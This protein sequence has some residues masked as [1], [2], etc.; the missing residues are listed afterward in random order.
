MPIF[1]HPTHVDQL[2]QI[3][4]ESYP[5]TG[6]VRTKLFALYWG[7]TM[8]LVV[9]GSIAAELCSMLTQYPKILLGEDTDATDWRGNDT[10]LTFE[11]KYYNA[12]VDVTA[13]VGD[14]PSQWKT[15]DEADAFIY[16]VTTEEAIE[17]EKKAEKAGDG[18]ES[19]HQDV[20]CDLS[21]E[22]D[23]VTRVLVV[24]GHDATSLSDKSAMF[25]ATWAIDRGFEYI[26]MPKEGRMAT[27]ADR[28][29]ESLPRLMEALESTQWR[30]MQPKGKDGSSSSSSAVRDNVFQSNTTTTTTTSCSGGGDISD[31]ANPFLVGHSD[32]DIHSSGSRQAQAASADS[33]ER[34]RE[35]TH[36]SGTNQHTTNTEEEG[37][38]GD[39]S[40]G[41]VGFEQLLEQAMKMRESVASGALGDAERRAQ[42][43]RFATQFAA[44][45][46][47]GEGGDSS[48][49]DDDDGGGGGGGSD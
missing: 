21:V 30:S 13:L 6:N 31:I 35:S 41:N 49:D 19:K 17:I 14:D 10:K 9:K 20:H 24:A 18:T 26:Y 43:E 22:K 8:S 39:N 1:G 44:M 4:V 40:D 25:W 42:A 3:S 48:D 16:V 29:K 27:A 11:T 36:G 12:E 46:D 47:F 34:E 2:G 37:G 45:L 33:K 23:V 7:C 32:D 28:E 15:L 5:P 38:E